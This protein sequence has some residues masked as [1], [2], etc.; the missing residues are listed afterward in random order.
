MAIS[1]RSPAAMQ[2]ANR[3]IISLITGELRT[4]TLEGSAVVA[5]IVWMRAK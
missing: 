2:L 5:E 1:L 3:T 4:N